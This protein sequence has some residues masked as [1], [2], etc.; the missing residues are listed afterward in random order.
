MNRSSRY[1]NVGQAIWLLVL[2]TLVGFGLS[3]PL[4]ILDGIVPFAVNEHPATIGAVNLVA[5]GFVLWW[6]LSR[7]GLTF[8]EAFSI[9]RFR[10]ALLLPVSLTM[11][12]MV[13]LLS[14]LD[15]AFRYFC[16]MPGWIADVFESVGGE[17]SLWGSLLLLV[18]IAPLTEELLFRGL[19]LRGLLSRYPVW[20]SVLIS[21][22]LFGLFHLN[23]WQIIGATLGGLILGWI[24]VRTRSLVPCVF[25]HALF[26]GM[27]LLLVNLLNLSIPGFSGDLGVEVEFQPIWLDIVGLS[28]ACFGL[29]LLVY[30]SR[31]REALPPRDSLAST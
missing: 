16:P 27:P 29:W 14:D 1:P 18:I 19:I 2:V 13:F 28:L 11:I 3:I 12:G 31:S 26:N 15:N 7:T 9:S 22:L 20:I 10:L 25:A 6:G 21:S 23:P 24:F 5:I 8:G 30:M 4:A 17:T